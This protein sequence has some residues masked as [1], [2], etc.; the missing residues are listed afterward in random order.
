MDVTSGMTA[1]QR[2]AFGKPFSNSS[3]MVAP[4]MAVVDKNTVVCLSVNK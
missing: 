3:E 4:A 2:Q 1:F